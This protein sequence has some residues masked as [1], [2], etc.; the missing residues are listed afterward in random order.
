VMLRETW[1]KIFCH[2][3]MT[4]LLIL[5]LALVRGGM[6]ASFL[7]PWGLIDEQQHVHYIQYVAENRA[8]PVIGQLYLSPEI[9]ESV[10]STRR[11]EVFHWSP[12]LVADPTQIGLEGHSYEGYQP[13]L[14]YIM[15]AFFFVILPGDMLFK[16]FALR[17]LMVVLSLSTV[18]ICY[19]LVRKVFPKY[20]MLPDIICLILVLVPERTMAVSRV[21]ND[22]LLEVIS[23]IFVYSCTS[24]ML[25][26]PSVR[27]SWLLGLWLGLGVL[28]KTS[29]GIMAAL[30]PFIFLHQ[31]DAANLKKLKTEQ[32]ARSNFFLNFM[33][34]LLRLI[35]RWRY[36]IFLI[37]GVAAL[38]IV[39]LVARNLYLYG[40]VTGFAGFREIKDVIGGFAAPDFT[41]SALKNEILD[42]F[43]HFWVVWW[44]GALAQNYPVPK[45]CLGAL[46]IASGFSLVGLMCYF[47][48]LISE[49][50]KPVNIWICLSYIVVVGVYGIM[51]I[52]ARFS[53]FM[54]V[55]QGRFL[56]P[57]ILPILVLFGVG[58]WYSPGQ[59]WLILSV[60]VV[61]LT[62]DTVTLAGSLYYHYYL[63]A[64][65]H[66]AAPQPFEPLLLPQMWATFY[67]RL[68]RDKPMLLRSFL[69]W[70]LPLYALILFLVS[71]SFFAKALQ[72]DV[73][74]L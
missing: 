25:K 9:V 17:W 11:W 4:L 59:K 52:V 73:E 10:F 60:I 49:K 63:S 44:G 24:A 31:A 26:P 16:L 18:V 15:M 61:L 6:Y 69:F 13:P 51:I 43:R 38:L 48:D 40:D 39:P 54:P 50:E 62:L 22:G 53:G 58:I 57:V 37:G 35:V 34:E 42:L 72:A 21:N 41:F 55:S 29:M 36:H 3:G 20:S 64:F 74:S 8:L 28:T 70:L 33:R 7:P 47:R 32:S 56:L 14:F 67:P 2:H 68:I 30:L 5:L 71:V 66:T 12:H 1:G 27:K 23:A 19:L 46:A 45:I 65:V